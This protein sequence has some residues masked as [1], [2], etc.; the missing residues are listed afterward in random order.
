VAIDGFA[1]LL[2]NL[3]SALESAHTL[4]MEQSGQAY[5]YILYR[6]TIHGP[7]EKAN[8]ELLGLHDRAHILL[9]GV[10]QTIIYRRDPNHSTTLSCSEGT[11]TLDVIVENMGRANYGLYFEEQKGITRGI[12]LNSQYLFNWQIYCLPF[13]PLP[14]LHFTANTAAVSQPAFLRATVHVDTPADT[15][16]DM[17]GFGKGVCFINGFNLGRFWKDGPQY[18]LYVPAPLLKS[19]ANEVTVFETDG[20]RSNSVRFS[21][22]PIF[23]KENFFVKRVINFFLSRI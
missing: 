17:R 4:S 5:G 10:L 11:H 19:G 3:P 22:G 23:K 8:L 14:G 16:L 7:L 15:W 12:A 1:P 13:A 2:D 6:T 18:T 20:L 21:S 9:D